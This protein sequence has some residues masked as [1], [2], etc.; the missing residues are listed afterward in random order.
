MNGIVAITIVAVLRFCR[1][2]GSYDLRVRLRSCDVLV[3][4]FGA[5]VLSDSPFILGMT[6]SG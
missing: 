5:S 6:I 1:F 4:S 2:F 3:A